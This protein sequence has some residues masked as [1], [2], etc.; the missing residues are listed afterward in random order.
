MPHILVTGASGFLGGRT[1]A[2]F[3]GVPNFS[4]RATSRSSK[5][6]GAL[7]QLGCE[8][9]AGDL[10]DAHFVSNLVEGID[11]IVHC[12]ALSSPYGVRSAFESANIT[13]TETLLQAARNTGVSKFIFIST[14]TIYVD[15]TSKFDVKE[16]DPLPR[17]PVNRYAETKLQAE[18]IVLANNSQ[19]IQTL[20][21]RPRAII[22]AE[23]TVIFPRVLNAYD[24]GKLKIVGKG[25]NL[26]DL[27]C[28]RNVVEA[29]H[30]AIHAPE[31]AFGEAYNIT[32][33]EPVNFWE[34]LNYALESLG[35][36]RVTKKVPKGLAIRVAG[37]VESYY[38]IFRPNNE[39]T[40][41]AY[42]IAVLADHFTMD[43]S[44]AKNLLNYKPV[45]TTKEGIDEFIAWHKSQ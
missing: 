45:M 20:A 7:T 18:R 29:I 2:H 33:G 42:G 26:C 25:D 21:L 38:K 14:P 39:P 19:A 12:A 5:K 27:T 28:A 13:A 40:L 17:K 9:V 15:L 30:C 43:I 8:F 1:A 36:Q 3:A 24:Q 11:I 10:T 4:V 23:D 6:A 44:K 16:S 31:H 37:L 41:T 34:M 22:G 35:Y 32:N